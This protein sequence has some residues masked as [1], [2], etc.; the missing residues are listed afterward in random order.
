[1][2]RSRRHGKGPR[3][4]S[5]RLSEADD[6]ADAARRLRQKAKRALTRP[7]L[8]GKVDPEKDAEEPDLPESPREVSD[9]WVFKKDR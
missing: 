5:W 2:S 9:R 6:K 7:P 3:V 4:S 8:V 1:M